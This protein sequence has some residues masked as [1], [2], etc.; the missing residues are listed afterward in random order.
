MSYNCH[1]FTLNQGVSLNRSVDLCC[2]QPSRPVS[3]EG[4]YTSDS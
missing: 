3:W 2:L 4:A 1:K